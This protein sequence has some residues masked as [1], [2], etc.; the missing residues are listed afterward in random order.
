MKRTWAWQYNQ[1][2]TILGKVHIVSTQDITITY[3][4]LHTILYP[5]SEN[6]YYIPSLQGKKDNYK[7]YNNFHH[8]SKATCEEF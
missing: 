8:N 7:L 4:N 5:S 1:L 2:K 3:N 6:L